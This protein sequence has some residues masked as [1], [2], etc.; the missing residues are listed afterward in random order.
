MAASLANR[1]RASRVSCSCG[2]LNGSGLGGPQSQQLLARDPLGDELEAAVRDESDLL[3]L[4]LVA[5]ALGEQRKLARVLQRRAARV[6]DAGE[7]EL[8]EAFRD[9][10]EM[11]SVEIDPDRVDR[12]VREALLERFAGIAER[13]LEREPGP[14]G[15]GAE[16]LLELARR[17]GLFAAKKRLGEHDQV[18]VECLDQRLEDVLGNRVRRHARP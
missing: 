4:P 14:T 18:G 11:R 8:V 3:D 13:E 7:Q 15:E 17:S 16:R 6:D 2:S 9:V 5:E 1:S 12:Q 10:R